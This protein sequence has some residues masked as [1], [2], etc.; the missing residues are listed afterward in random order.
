MDEALIAL[1]RKGRLKE[2][3]RAR[4][5]SSRE[6]ARKLW[7][8]VSPDNPPRLVTWVSPTFENDKLLRRSHFRVLSRARHI[9]LKR[10][11][12]QEEAQ[13]QRVANESPEHVLAKDLITAALRRRL[14]SG[15]AMPWYF[16][17]PD[18]TDFHLAGNLLLGAAD[19]QKEYRVKT[20]FG[21]EYRLDVAVISKTI[22][23]RPLLLGG[24]EIERGHAFDGRKALIGK[25]QAFPLI[26]IDITEMALNEITPEWAD[27]ALTATTRS[28]D[29]RRRQTYVYLHD[30]LYPLYTQVPGFI[31]KEK[32]HQFVVFA[33][34]GQ[35]RTLMNWIKRLG[36]TLGLGS[37]CLSV[38]LVNAKSEQSKKMLLN[39]GDVVGSDWFDINDHQC[40]RIT[41]E[42]PSSPMDA[43]NHLFHIGLAKLLLAH[44]D[45]LVGY[46]Y[47]NGILN[48]DLDEDIW[49][50]HQ[51]DPEHKCF[52]EHRVLPKRLA[53]PSSRILDV[54]NQ[55]AVNS[56]D[57]DMAS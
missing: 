50:H 45:A 22:N 14:Q 52:H 57:A 46:K 20:S 1:S 23:Q 37:S 32:S 6:H 53:E 11:F 36:E 49:I 55:L 19:V 42:R 26:S 44:A 21:S 40:L 38:A 30:L 15:L 8:L 54:L 17:D 51:W 31:A 7:P 9:D 47:R 48:D 12:E 25:S 3:I 18:A 35:L 43:V 34:D 24:V 29:D 16:S 33:E 5:I 56:D 39:A 27:R 41:V 13:R 28:G 10:H 2:T 4:D